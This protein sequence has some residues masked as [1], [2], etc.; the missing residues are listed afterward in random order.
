MSELE[1]EL[2][3]LRSA[4]EEKEAEL[5]GII[6]EEKQR[7]EAELHVKKLLFNLNFFHFVDLV[8]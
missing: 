1:A 6:K 8:V 2:E 5:C 4:L 3:Q 7:K